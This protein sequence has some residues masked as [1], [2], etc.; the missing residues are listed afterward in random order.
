MALIDLKKAGG[1]PLKLDGHKLVFGK[2]M[3][4][5]VPEART[6]KRMEAVLKNPNVEAPPEFYYMYRDVHLKKDAAK[7]RANGLRYD[8]TVLPAFSVGGEFNKTFGHCHPKVTG[9]DTWYPE[10][11]EVLHGRAH[12]LQQNGPE[13]LVFDCRTGDKCVMLPGFAHVTVNPSDSETLVLANWVCPGFE[14]DYSPIEAKRGAM[15]YETHHGFVPNKAYESAPHVR[16]ASPKEF[17]EFG[18]TKKPIYAEAVK[19]PKK[20]AWLVRPQGYGALFK[21]Y[22]ET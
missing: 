3:G 10:V 12:F 13:F 6:Y 22:R 16:L 4:I 9:T 7:I 15:Y 8:I 20:F 21:K 18:I 11:Y 5:A 19:N 2:G 14:S 1:L 17:P